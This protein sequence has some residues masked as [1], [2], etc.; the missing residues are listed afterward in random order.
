MRGEQS[1]AM[2][3]GVEV[4]PHGH[5]AF[6]DTDWDRDMVAV[7]VKMKNEMSDEIVNAVMDILVD[8]LDDQFI[9]TL[10]KTMVKRTSSIDEKEMDQDDKKSLEKLEKGPGSDNYVD[11]TRKSML[12][13]WLGNTV[14]GPFFITR[15]FSIQKVTKIGCLLGP[16][17]AAVRNRMTSPIFHEHVDHITMLD[18][19]YYMISG[20]DAQDMNW[21]N[22]V[23]CDFVAV[24]DKGQKVRVKQIQ[25]IKT[26]YT[27]YVDGR[28]E[29][30]ENAYS[31]AI[32]EDDSGKFLKLNYEAGVFKEVN[33][34]IARIVNTVSFT[35]WVKSKT[36]GLELWYGRDEKDKIDDHRKLIQMYKNLQQ[37]NTQLKKELQKGKRGSK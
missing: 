4:K 19:E 21:P 16:V 2:A 17:G 9:E 32:E 23:T 5:L 29:T 35:D 7:L 24:A 22:D 15:S 18:D 36:I 31:V 28:P 34:V 12:K 30:V 27:K 8:V 33:N 25:R 3:L 37:E 20:R 11:A 26:L 6:K 14:V 13:L 10:L 1:W